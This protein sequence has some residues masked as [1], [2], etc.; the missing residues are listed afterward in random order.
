[1]PV[2]FTGKTAND[3]WRQAA[4]AFT[5]DQITLQQGRGGE[6]REIRQAVISISNPRER[7]VYSRRPALN[8]AFALA[9][10]IWILAGRKDSAFLTHWNTQLSRYAGSGPYF[11]GAYGKRLR[12]GL[13]FDQLERACHALT[14]QPNS[15]QVVLQIWDGRLDFPT[16]DG[17][18]RSTDIPCNVVS[19]LKIRDNKL[20][21]SQIL[22]SN[23][24]F[25]GLPHNIVQFTMLQ[26]VIAGWLGIEVGT[27]TH[28]S[29]SLHVYSRDYDKLAPELGDRHLSNSDQLALSTEES[30]LTWK[31]LETLVEL[32]VSGDLQEHE[33]LQ[34]S[35]D[36]DLPPAHQNIACILAAEDARR[37]A[38]HE[39]SQQCISNCRNQVYNLLWTNWMNRV[40][41]T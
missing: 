23:D 31:R 30:R 39:I 17:T 5:Q 8:P 12:Q 29:D 2:L 32:L 33:Y 13:G 27:Y 24:L 34:V 7:W 36:Y 22:R 28:F 9:E 25:L 21:W 6:T 40:S 3:V 1:M 11:Y 37:R 26:E 14:G 19:M 20:E 41:R 4:T 38:F 35:E 16:S 15:R 18:P 10:V